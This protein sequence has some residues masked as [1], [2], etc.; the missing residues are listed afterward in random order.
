MSLFQDVTPVKLGQSAIT[1]AIA[2]LYTVPANKRAFVKDIDLSNNNAT[3]TAV[4]VYLVPNGG[5]AG[6]TN[7]L[8]PGMSVPNNGMLQW[9][10]SQIMNAGDSIQT[11]AA[12]T[13]VTIT[14]SGGEAV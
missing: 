5:T 6:A 13:G 4:N 3:P 8:I 2:T 9:T 7:I 1:V 10:G 12:A 14:A 11:S